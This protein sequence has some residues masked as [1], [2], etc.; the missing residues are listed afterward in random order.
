ML[1][2]QHL[3]QVFCD[4]PCKKVKNWSWYFG[5][6]QLCLRGLRSNF[7]VAGFMKN[8]HLT[9]YTFFISI[10]FSLPVFIQAVMAL[11]VTFL[12]TYLHILNQ[13]ENLSIQDIFLAVRFLTMLLCQARKGWNNFLVTF[14]S[15]GLKSTYIPS[16]LILVLLV[17]HQIF[18]HRY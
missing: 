18:I 12:Q 11:W 9:S 2:L 4:A 8:V 13:N 16:L 3:I 1:L 6:N 17:L 7:L 15:Y 14:Y 5:T 10:L